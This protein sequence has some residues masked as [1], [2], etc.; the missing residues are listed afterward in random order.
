MR[1]G[2]HHSR[3]TWALLVAASCLGA[4]VANGWHVAVETHVHHHR[5]DL[6]GQEHDHSPAEEHAPHQ[7]RDHEAPDGTPWSPPVLVLFSP[8]VLIEVM[9]PAPAPLRP[10]TGDTRE[11]P[12]DPPRPPG[13]PRAPPVA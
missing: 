10:R 8:D 5:A 9:A 11:P 4:W 6:D 12:T 7:A 1:T 3:R 13:R 2:P